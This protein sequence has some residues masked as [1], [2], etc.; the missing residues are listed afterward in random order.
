MGNLTLQWRKRAIQGVDWTTNTGSQYTLDGEVRTEHT[1]DPY[2]LPDE[3]ILYQ[4]NN[5][6]FTMEK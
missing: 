2:T 5:T 4:D 6:K 3:K 1:H